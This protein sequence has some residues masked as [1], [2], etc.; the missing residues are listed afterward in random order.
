MASQISEK[1]ARQVA[2]SAREQGWEKPSFGK[3]AV[4]RQP[5][6]RPHPPPAEARPGR[7]REGRGVPRPPARVPR[8]ARRPARDRARRADPRRRR[9]R[10]Q[11]AR[12]ARHEGA[13]VLRR[14]R[15][16]AGPL[17]PRARARRHVAFGARH[18]ALRAPVDRRRRAADGLRLRGAEAEVAAARRARPHLRLPADRARR[19][20]GSRPP[21]HDG[22]AGRGRLRPQRPQAVGDQ[23]RRRRHRRRH[24]PGAEVR[25]PQGRHHGLRPRLSTPT[26][27]PSSTATSSWACAGSRTR[28]RCSRT[29]S[30]RART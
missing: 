7:G 14:A 25:G 6:A 23:R 16:L 13:R 18:A 12:R 24:G 11:G 26:A 2:E 29:S 3:R 22:R 21:R 15:P 4:P 9:R 30:C 10:A 28:P 19:R 5:G 1:E 8:R 27:S 17:Q 20:L